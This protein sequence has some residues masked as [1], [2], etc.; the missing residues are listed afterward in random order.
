MIYH[1]IQSNLSKI[2]NV[3]Y[4]STPSRDYIF[5]FYNLSSKVNLKITLLYMKF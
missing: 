4:R 2:Y 1:D 5:T 3:K